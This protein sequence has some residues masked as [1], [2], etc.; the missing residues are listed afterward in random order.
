MYILFSNVT[1]CVVHINLN[2][3]LESVT[4]LM[5]E[6]FCFAISDSPR[7]KLS[8]R[9]SGPLCVTFHPRTETESFCPNRRFT[10][11]RLLFE[12]ES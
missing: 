3:T 6:I 10:L 11:S 5:V 9:K 7:F 8:E 4:C 1:N 2:K 12:R